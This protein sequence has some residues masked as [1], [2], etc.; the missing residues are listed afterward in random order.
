M[1]LISSTK[2]SEEKDHDHI[3]KI[4]SAKPTSNFFSKIKEANRSAGTK[5]TVEAGS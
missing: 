1:N 4:V 3:K 5:K 2:K